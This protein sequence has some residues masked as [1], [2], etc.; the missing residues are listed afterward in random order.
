MESNVSNPTRRAQS[1]T[2]SKRSSILE[3]WCGDPASET[4]V[5]AVAM[6]PHG[7]VEMA[8]C[9]ATVPVLELVGDIMA[10]LFSHEVGLVKSLASFPSSSEISEAWPLETKISIIIYWFVVVKRTEASDSSSI[11]KMSVQLERFLV[12]SRYSAAVAVQSLHRRFAWHFQCGRHHRNLVKAGGS[13]RVEL[14][15]KSRIVEGRLL[16]EVAGHVGVSGHGYCVG[17]G[18]IRAVN[19][20]G[21]PH[22]LG[23]RARRSGQGHGLLPE[24]GGHV[25]SVGDKAHGAVRCDSTGHVL[26]VILLL[27]LSGTHLA[28]LLLEVLHPLL[29]AVACCSLVS[30]TP[31][32]GRCTLVNVN[33]RYVLWATLFWILFFVF[34][35][36]ST[37]DSGVV[38]RFMAVGGDWLPRG[39]MPAED[40]L[41][42]EDMVF[43]C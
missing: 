12:G 31:Q 9:G 27:L 40:V 36:A 19:G 34:W 3:N 22:L 33:S 14:V 8:L 11:S 24:S 42:A 37:R 26:R 17:H 2:C 28:K 16:V 20:H 38:S 23:H 41:E 13:R 25:S 43:L 6:E 30:G 21:R 5:A 18:L 4:S 15:E 32:R 7:D 10:G 39:R 35:S 1:R 29:H